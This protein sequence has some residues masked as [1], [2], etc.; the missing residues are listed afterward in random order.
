MMAAGGGVPVPRFPFPGHLAPLPAF[1]T[2]LAPSATFWYPTV[3]SQANKRRALR[4]GGGVPL[5]QE[6]ARPRSRSG[7][8]GGPWGPVHLAWRPEGHP[9]SLASNTSSRL[10]PGPRKTRVSWAGQ[11]SGLTRLQSWRNLPFSTCVRSPGGPE[12]SPQ[13]PRVHRPSGTLGWWLPLPPAGPGHG[14]SRRA[15]RS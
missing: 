1:L 5:G 4:N 3:T 6:D 11:G 15:R 7:A 8:P 12:L 14:V 10:H 13:R 2:A 9:S